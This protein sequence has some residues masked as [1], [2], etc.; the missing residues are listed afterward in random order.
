MPIYT[1][2]SHEFFIPEQLALVD[3]N[4]LNTAF[5]DKGAR[6]QNTRFFLDEYL[7]ELELSPIVL[8]EVV[9]EMWG[10]VVG[11]RKAKSCGLEILSWLSDTNNTTLL[12]LERN[13]F[14]EG[15]A[16]CIDTEIDYVDSILIASAFG[17]SRHCKLKAPL[18]IITF[19]T[20]DYYHF[21]C[22]SKKTIQLINPDEY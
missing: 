1:L 18:P 13:I 11:S 2:L 5:Y 8:L 10:L 12:P 19:E 16:L 9:V 22:K 21:M 7:G 15:H 20:R 6:G 17:L 14:D 4:V 3:T